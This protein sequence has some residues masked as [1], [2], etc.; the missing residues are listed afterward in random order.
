MFKMLHLV[1]VVS[2]AIYFLF[3]SFLI[4]KRESGKPVCDEFVPES[5]LEMRQ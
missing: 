1:I 4:C 5:A 2:D 3:E